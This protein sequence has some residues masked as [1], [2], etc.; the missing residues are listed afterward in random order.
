MAANHL[1]PG[2]DP[3][4][5]REQSPTSDPGSPATFPL[6][7]NPSSLVSRP[8]GEHQ[9]QL[10]P[11]FQCCSS[12]FHPLDS[13]RGRAK[14]DRKCGG[15]NETFR[16]TPLFPTLLGHWEKEAAADARPGTALSSERS[17]YLWRRGYYEAYVDPPWTEAVYL[18]IQDAEGQ[19][20]AKPTN[21]MAFLWASWGHLAAGY[22]P[23]WRDPIKPLL[24][25]ERWLH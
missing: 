12:S 8:K 18:C 3:R 17:P 7:L 1:S 22:R 23:R 9:A 5:S 21:F 10:P 6:C 19:Q 11:P 16:P 2:R 4:S 24:S 14:P 25:K 13:K 15:M 20:Q